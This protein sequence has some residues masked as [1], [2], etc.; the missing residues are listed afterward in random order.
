MRLI[1]SQISFVFVRATFRGRRMT[2]TSRSLIWS[3]TL[4][5]LIFNP[6]GN[7]G[8]VLRTQ[9][10]KSTLLT[11]TL[12]LLRS[13]KVCPHDKERVGC[14]KKRAATASILPKQNCNPGS[15]IC[16]GRSAFGQNYS[17]GAWVAVKD[18]PLGRTLWWWPWKKLRLTITFSVLMSSSFM[19]LW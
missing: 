7:F 12:G 6:C 4:M 10:A 18:L 17:L 13:F 8:E 9:L 16:C 14:G 11:S 1:F 2:R 3:K 19:K 5:E 15:W